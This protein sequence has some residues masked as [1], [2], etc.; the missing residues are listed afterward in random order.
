LLGFHAVFDFA[1]VRQEVEEPTDRDRDRDGINDEL[2][3]CP[4]IPEDK[5]GFEDQDGCPD[6]DN[7]QDGVLD[8]RD[9]CPMDPEDKDGFEDKDGCP[10]DD[11]DKD[12]VLDKL[13]KCPT[14]PEDRDGFEDEDGCPEDDNDQDGV[15]DAKDLC[16]DYPETMNIYADHDGCPDEE[17]VRVVGDKIVL[18]DRVHFYTNS[19]TIRAVSYPLLQRLSK[20]VSEHPEYTHIGIEGHADVRGPE[21]YNKPLSQRRAEAVL[22]FMVKHG[23]ARERLSAKGFGSERPLVD[24]ESEHG[25]LL[26]RRVEFVVTRKIKQTLGPDAK[27]VQSAG[28]P[29]TGESEGSRGPLEQD[30]DAPHSSDEQP[31]TGPAPAPAEGEKP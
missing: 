12:G 23:V 11:N 27:P 29:A 30:A 28:E 15:V 16:P 13:D 26:N 7:D 18:D 24:A 8:Q 1:P 4:D 20:L 9:E 10:E 25:Y 2:D 19:H 5:D 17:Q 14:D 6:D 3:N 22:E 31:A 21:A